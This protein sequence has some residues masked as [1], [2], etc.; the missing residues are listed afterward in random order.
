LQ[1]PRNTPLGECLN[2]L[3]RSADGDLA[4]KWDDDDFYAPLYLGD[5]AHALAYSGADI[6]G[7]RA[8]YMHLAGPKATI[9]RNPQLEHRFVSAVMGPTI[10][11][12]SETLTRFPFLPIP[13]G[14]DSQFLKDAVRA[15]ATI[16]SADRFN[17][18][19]MRG[20]DA[21]SHTWSIADD[22]LLASSKIQFFGSPE[23]H[24]IV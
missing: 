2:A 5:L 20:R 8:H 21:S 23:E 22:Q 17:Y 18:C 24:V 6:V 4:T 3:V 11:G 12:S 9:L 10:L 7:K 1:E 15:G 19:Q 14:E 16:Y 13:T